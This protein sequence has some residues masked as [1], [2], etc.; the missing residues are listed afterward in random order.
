MPLDTDPIGGR[1]VG[2]VGFAQ[3]NLYRASLGNVNSILNRFRDVLKQVRHL[4]GRP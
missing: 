1:K 3:F 2:Q 4:F